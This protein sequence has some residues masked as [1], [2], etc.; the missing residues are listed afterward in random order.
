MRRL[1][2]LLVALISALLGWLFAASADAATLTPA[3]IE[4]GYVYDG[5]QHTSPA[6]YTATD[7]GRPADSDTVASVDAVDRWSRG[8]SERPAT[9]PRATAITYDRP[10][11]LVQVARAPATTQD[12]ARRCDGE[13]SSLGSRRVAAKFIGPEAALGFKTFDAA[14][15][16]PELA[17]GLERTGSALS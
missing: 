13:I 1:L 9:A 14:K 4:S 7:R 16:A 2:P 5:H 11:P 15:T 17:S 12:Q 8:A 3:H 6:T 10:T